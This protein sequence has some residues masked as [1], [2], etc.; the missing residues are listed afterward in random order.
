MEGKHRAILR[1]Y[2]PNIVKDLEPN[3]IIP[4][5]GSVLTAKDDAEIKAQSTRQGRCE[6]LLDIIPRKGPNAFKVFVEALKE[7]APHL[8]SDLID[9]DREGIVRE[10]SANLRGEI[11]DLETKLEAEKQDH[12]K[13]S[14]E[15]EELKSLHETFKTETSQQIQKLAEI[16]QQ[17]TDD[18]CCP[19][20]AL[21]NLRDSTER[22]TQTSEIQELTKGITKMV[23]GYRSLQNEHGDLSQELEKAKKLLEDHDKS[24][25][26]ALKLK[27]KLEKSQRDLANKNERV[28]EYQEKLQAKSKTIDYLRKKLKLNAMEN[29]SLQKKLSQEEG[30]ECDT[31]QE[32]VELP[33]LRLPQIYSS[34]LAT[35]YGKP[36]LDA[37]QRY[38][39]LRLPEVNLHA[40]VCTR[41]LRPCEF[42]M[43]FTSRTP[44]KEFY[45]EN[46]PSCML[47]P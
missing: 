8:A 28:K 26:E 32:E 3:N 33:R 35:N 23:E 36:V 30:S 38:G 31:L 39:L 37:G 15:L 2:R 29:K 9:A 19:C 45:A 43:M 22:E 41:Q 17:L 44:F 4:D 20:E 42:A 25:G 1:H 46:L 13:T 7:E 21:R 47:G 34:D 12:G 16:V 24:K 6:Q 14:Q 27:T 40:R 18:S 11:R 5:L 10:Q